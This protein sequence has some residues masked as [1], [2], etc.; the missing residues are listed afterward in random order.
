MYTGSYI[1]KSII[2]IKED[3]LDTDNF[4]TI[5]FNFLYDTS[6]INTPTTDEKERNSNKIYTIDG[7]YMGTDVNKL[8]KGIYIRNR[9]KIII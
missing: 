4:A 5:T 1:D 8:K 3:T 9:Q 7:I 2:E 6:G